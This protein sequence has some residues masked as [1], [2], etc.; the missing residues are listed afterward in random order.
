[1]SQC[2]AGVSSPR[3]QLEHFT[4]SGLTLNCL[5][6]RAGSP[7]GLCGQLRERF[8]RLS[9]NLHRLPCSHRSAVLCPQR[10]GRGFF[11][12]GP[13]GRSRGG[14]VATGARQQFLP[15]ESECRRTHGWRGEMARR[16]DGRM[17]G[18]VFFFGD[19]ARLRLGSGFFA[20]SGNDIRLDA[21]IRSD[22]MR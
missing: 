21:K 17:E 14:G 16:R 6:Q 10:S 4:G 9:Q 2:G 5:Q 11:R 20:T 18:D 15:G 7:S 3:Q 13:C 22:R 8:A 19:G 12:R 1:M